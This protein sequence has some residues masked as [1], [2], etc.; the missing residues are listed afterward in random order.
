MKSVT[1]M[2]WKIPLYKIEWSNSDLKNITEIIKSGMFWT[3]GENI[4]LFESA[5]AEFVETKYAVSFNSG[6]SA[7]H[8][9]LIALNVGS[10]DEVI[11]PSFTFIATA[12]APLFVNAESIFADIEE[13]T[14]G[15]NPDDVIN[16]ITKKTK[17]IMP[18]HYGGQSCKIDELRKICD[19]YNLLLIED[20]AEALGSIFKNKMC[21]SFG[22][23]G[24]FSFTDAKI[25][26]SGEG[27][28]ITTNSQVI[29]D[30]LKRIR[31][32]GRVERQNY[33]NSSQNFDYIELGYNFRM[34][35]II[36]TLALSQFKNLQSKIQARRSNALQM[37][38]LL[39]DIDDIIT[40]QFSKDRFQTFQMYS[41]RTNN[42]NGLMKYLNENGIMTKI[43]FPPIHKSI[44][45]KKTLK[46]DLM[47]P[48]TEKVSSEILSLPMYPGLTE[49]EM[50]YIS[51]KIHEFKERQ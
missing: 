41:I 13:E 47:L 37:N 31:S 7:L 25:C 32:H 26:T 17:V 15:L 9:I 50:N 38:K 49:N 34:S 18:I 12:N 51:D 35:N 46:Y 8:A 45:H 10:G 1:K 39:S 28:M 44:Y 16:K 6:T 36:A 5:I 42:R 20:S 27:G 3:S 48:V 23:A 2:K 14:F 19:D 43:W 24:M 21:G 30:R 22:D 4:E 29:N 33:F 40:P 11:V